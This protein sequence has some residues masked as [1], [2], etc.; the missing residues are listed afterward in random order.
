MAT[1]ILNKKG[2]SL[3]ESMIS[4][5]RF[6]RKVLAIFCFISLM[7]T[8][9]I[10]PE[11]IG[12][13]FLAILLSL[14]NIMCLCF[15][16][17]VRHDHRIVMCGMAVYVPLVTFESFFDILHMLKSTSCPWPFVLNFFLNMFIYGGLMIFICIVDAKRRSEYAK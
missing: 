16:E 9:V 7:S 2:K 17:R 14:Y 5:Q 4:V 13:K 8:L 12:N 11:Y 10:V 15:F 1:K 3:K 6:L